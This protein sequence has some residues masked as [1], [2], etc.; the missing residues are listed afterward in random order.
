MKKRIEHLARLMKAHGVDRDTA[1]N[2][3]LRVRKE[4]AREQMI[5][6]L[7][8]NPTATPDEISQKSRDVAKANRHRNTYQ[9]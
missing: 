9:T 5:L 4:E 3:S 6:W 2:V 7:E 8:Q 1:L